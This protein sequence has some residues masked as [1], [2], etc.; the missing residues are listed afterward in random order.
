MF[1]KLNNDSVGYL[2]NKNLTRDENEILLLK[3]R[4]HVQ[5]HFSV[6]FSFAV[7]KAYKWIF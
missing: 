4:P 6:V 7:R 5:F 2:N 1:R 3:N